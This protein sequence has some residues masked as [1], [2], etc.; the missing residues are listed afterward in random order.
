MTGDTLAQR[1]ERTMARIEQIVRAVYNVKIQWQCT[2]D[3]AN[4]TEKT[5]ELLTH[6]TLRHS[7][8]KTRDDLYMGSNGG[9]VSSLQD[10]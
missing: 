5:P 8:L 6:P 4:I 2:F 7:P 3:E 9:H 10:Q 1:Y